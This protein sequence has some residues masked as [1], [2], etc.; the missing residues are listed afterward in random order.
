M[1]LTENTRISEL[2]KEYPWLID[3]AVKFDERAGIVLHN[4]VAKLFLKKATI[5]SL[6]EKAGMAPDVII[7][8]IRELIDHH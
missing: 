1:I 3:E 6:S 4:P 2:L 5:R 7:D 8:R